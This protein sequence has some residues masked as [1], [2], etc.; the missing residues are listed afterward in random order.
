MLFSGPM[1]SGKTEVAINFAVRAAVEGAGPVRLVD[2]DFVNP[3]FCARE[4]REELSLRGVEVVSAP[5]ERS[6]SDIPVILGDLVGALS[7]E[8]GLTVVDLGGGEKGASMLGGLLD[9]L[10]KGDVEH[11]LVVNPYRMG[12]RPE[13][14]IVNVA[15]SIEEAAKKRLTGL[16]SNPHLGRGTKGREIKEG[17]KVV[18]RASFVLGVPIRFLACPKGLVGPGGEMSGLKL[19]L[20]PLDFF[21]KMPWEG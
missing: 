17:H 18:G 10:P 5:S 20:L 9:S 14:Q 21:V 16:V 2:L 12:M 19:P 7:R 1:G 15:R 3:Y 4:R 6:P 11:L 13:E 8:E